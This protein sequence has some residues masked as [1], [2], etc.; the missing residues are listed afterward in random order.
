MKTKLK[1]QEG[2]N[3]RIEALF[4]AKG[5]EGELYK[6]VSPVYMKNKCVKLILQ[7]KWTKERI[8]KI[9]YM[10]AHPPSN[11]CGDKYE[12]CWPESLIYEGNRPI[13]FIM[14]LANSSAVE[15]KKLC[16]E[17]ISYDIGTK[18]QTKFK[19]NYP[20]CLSI[21]LKICYNIARVIDLIHKTGNYVFLDLKPENIL[22]T[23]NGKIFIIDCDSLQ[24]SDSK[25]VL[26]AGSALTVKYAP[27]ESQSLSFIKDKIPITWDQFSI[28][29]VFY[30][31]LFGIH[32][33]TATYKAPYDKATSLGS[34]I[35]EELFVHGKKNK[36]LYA[37]PPP[38]TEYQFL[39]AHLKQL[40]ERALGRSIQL[41]PTMFEWG[42]VILKQFQPSPKP[43]TNLLKSMEAFCSRISDFISAVIDFIIKVILFFIY[44]GFTISVLFAIYKYFFLS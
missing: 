17:T 29:V 41:R 22:I 37:C 7:A 24:V 43:S 26:F 30:E 14:P 39:D 15:L 32:P 3:I 5:G 25:Q 1:T 31:I 6:I 2:K 28:A 44:L 21:R 38:H 34:K 40:F 9:A 8:Q 19:R 13:G 10:I 36:W 42:Q 11:L 20:Q 16:S 23:L 18:W 35:A 27:P 33:F 4:F 12:I